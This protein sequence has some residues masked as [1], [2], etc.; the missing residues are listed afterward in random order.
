MACGRSDRHDQ[1]GLPF[2]LP[3]LQIINNRLLHVAVGI[4]RHVQRNLVEIDAL[5]HLLHQL[6]LESH[7]LDREWRRG[8][9]KGMNK[10]NTLR[11]RCLHASRIEERDYR[12]GRDHQEQRRTP[13]FPDVAWREQIAQREEPCR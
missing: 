13:R 10:E 11:L 7:G 4:A 2:A 9:A 8:A 3:L 1:V 12:N 6:S 5:A